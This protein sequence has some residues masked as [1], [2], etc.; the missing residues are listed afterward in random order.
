MHCGAASENEKATGVAFSSSGVGEIRPQ[1]AFHLLQCLRFDLADAF[2]GNTE[3]GSEIVQVAASSSASQRASMIRRLRASR[4]SSA[5][6]RPSLC[7]W[8]YREPPARASARCCCRP[9][10]RSGRTSR[11]RRHAIPAPCHGAEAGLHLGH[12]FRLD[13]KPLCDVERLAGGQCFAAR[14]HAAQVEEQLA[15][16]LVVATFTRRQFFSTYS[17][18]SAL[19]QWIANETRRTPR[20]GS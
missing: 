7:R 20:S 13:A 5:A 6:R 9:A 14:F 2:G 10:R 12:F 17:W 15:L 19:I 4:L 1:H 11:H 3:F 8:S 18:I 16:G